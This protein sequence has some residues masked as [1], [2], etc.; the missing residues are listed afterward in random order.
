MWGELQIRELAV[1]LSGWRKEMRIYRVVEVVGPCV[2]DYRRIAV[3]G[4]YTPRPFLH[5][6]L[7]FNASYQFTQL[8]NLRLLVFGLTPF[9]W[10]RSVMLSPYF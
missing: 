7:C 6:F 3:V 2:V 4:N 9:G 5:L 10:L 1:K 8:L